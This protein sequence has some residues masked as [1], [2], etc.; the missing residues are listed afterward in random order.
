VVLIKAYLHKSA[1]GSNQTSAVAQSLVPQ[2]L[3][4]LSLIDYTRDGDSET[5][6]YDRRPRRGGI[7]QE[8]P[9]GEQKAESVRRRAE[10][11]DQMFFILTPDS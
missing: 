9:G 1:R 6:E 2:G 3:C 7:E 10:S 4:G 8:D 11:R 5:G